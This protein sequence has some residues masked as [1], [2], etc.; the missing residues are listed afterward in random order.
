MSNKNNLRDHLLVVAG[1]TVESWFDTDDFID[2]PDDE[3]L[4]DLAINI[5]DSYIAD[6]DQDDF[7]YYVRTKLVEEF[8][9]KSPS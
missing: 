8:I 3:S 7:P 5:V 9:F 4:V 1:F 6:E 2:R